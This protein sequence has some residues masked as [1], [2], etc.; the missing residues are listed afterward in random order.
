M[1]QL[2]CSSH[3]SF[4]HWHPEFSPGSDGP[5]KVP[6]Q[7]EV[8]LP[9]F[10]TDPGC[11]PPGNIV[12]RIQDQRSA[13]E[14]RI[15]LIHDAS[16]PAL[17]PALNPGCFPTLNRVKSRKQNRAARVWDIVIA[18]KLSEFGPVSLGESLVARC[19]VIRLQ[20]FSVFTGP[21]RSPA[22]GTS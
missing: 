19:V 6:L 15:A 9:K 13:Y 22:Y 12:T 21:S 8:P 20:Q 18:A 17:N 5:P 1:K 7:T 16:D 11:T 14:R 10:S 4:R 3:L 2:W